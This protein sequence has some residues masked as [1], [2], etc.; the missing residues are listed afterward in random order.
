MN[1]HAL[2][3]SQGW[4]G[5]GH[6]LHHSSDT[7]GLSRP[8]LVSKKDNVLGVGKKQHK[9][10]DMWWMNAFDASLKGLDTSKEGQI[11][12]QKGGGLEMVVKGGSKWVGGKGGLYSFFVRGE[13]VGGTIEDKEKE[14]VE[15]IVKEEKKGKGKEKDKKRKGEERK[16]SKEER[17]ERKEKKRADRARKLAA[18]EAENIKAQKE[19]KAKSSKSIDS[20]KTETKEERRERK[21]RKQQKKLLRQPKKESSDTSST[22]EI[23]KKKKKSRKDK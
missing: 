23:T 8:L 4:R 14:V 21:E 5:T 19:V 20:E 1:A 3:T 7:I 15:I 9:T 12:V 16:E 17:R 11:K 22:S 13:T 10:S 18:V 6:S 2:L